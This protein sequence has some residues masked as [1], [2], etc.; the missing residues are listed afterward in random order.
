MGFFDNRG[1]LGPPPE[2]FRFGSSGKST[3]MPFRWLG[4]AALVLVGYLTISVLKTIYV[5]VL[6][7]D[8]VG[9]GGV[10]QTELTARVALFF[11]GALIA[12][13]VLG[14]NIILARRFAPVGLE[15]SFIEEVDPEAI[16]RIVAV[17]LVAG[18]LFLGVIFGSVAA[19]N[20]ETILSW[21]NSQP[22][23]REDA[24]F[25][26]DIGFYVFSL[27][28]LHLIQQWMLSLLFVSAL[29]SAGVYALSISLQRFELN[30][31]QQMRIH[32]SFLVGAIFLA[33]AASTML[34]VYDIVS[35]SGGIVY[36]AKYTDVNARLPVRYLLVALSLFAA[37]ATIANPFLSAQGFRAP[38]FAIGLWGFAGI[39]GGVLYPAIVQ[40]VTVEPNER[41]REA[42]YIERNIAA[43]RFA[44]GLDPVVETR[45]PA[46]QAVKQADLDANP[47]T[48]AN[49][50]LL[51]PIPLRDTFNQIQ[52]IRQFYTFNDVDVARY[53]INGKTQQVMAAAR[54]LDITRAQGTN[55]TR[56][57]LQLTH[58]YGAVIAPVNEVVNEGLP[59]LITSEIPPKSDVIKITEAGARIYFGEK[60]DQYVVGRSSEPE[61]DYPLGNGNAA[62]SYPED[63]GIQLNSTLRRA[64][65]AWELGDANLL[66]SGQIT[67]ES[68]LLMDR[69]I[70]QRVRKVAPFLLLDSDPYMVVIDGRIMWLQSAYTTSTRFPYAQPSGL[71][72]EVNYVRSSVQITID[73]QT[74]DMHFYL[75]DSQDPIAKTWSRI[76]P[77]LFE[78]NDAIPAAVRAHMRYPLDLF[79]LQSQLYL[80]YHITDPSVFFIGE[81]VWNIPAETKNN[82]LQAIEPYYVTMVLPDEQR[83]AGVDRAEFVL[84]M[85]F[86]PRNRQNTVA[87]LAGRSDGGNLGKLRA[88]RFPTEDLVFG[89]AQ[90]EARIDQN[91]G[92]SQQITLWNQSGSSV[93]RG[94]LL[95]IPVGTSFLFVEPIYL[96]SENSKLPELVRVV[97]ANGTQIAM[98]R[99]FPEALDVVMGKR[100]SS[101]ANGPQAAPTAPATQPGATATPARGTA[102]PTATPRPGATPTIAPATI[103]ELLR[104]AQQSSN[105]TQQELDRLRAILEAI[106]KQ[107][108]T[109]PQ[110]PAR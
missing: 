103:E 53:T 75:L 55:W 70:Q 74:G 92:I 61:F 3:P 109:Q 67:S 16:R 68:R 66:I 45:F 44:Y 23:G 17:L 108:Q 80:R 51:D 2:A 52:A 41:L 32:L 24:Q 27:P 22:F 43:T 59:K 87:W 69:Q 10:Y 79:K 46:E 102:T 95:M 72:G 77:G 25:Q 93:V 97:V 82:K 14:G 99:T 5:D 49:I 47:E 85:P 6:W 73:A 107:L 71:L 90:I 21:L 42:P 15:E 29:A 96:Q 1:D 110:T 50:R 98:E 86:T 56:E 100:P 20:W 78:P 84:I 91:P 11:A 63:R 35:S 30:L 34:N 101:L 104:Q 76:F 105:T 28:A 37:T 58:G 12:V 62:T 48:L 57:R 40:S 13:A 9:F 8:S 89:P 7:F 33:I 64:M 36:G 26:R 88:Y 106:Q 65:L 18:T 4:L 31:N 54:E 38:L 83:A 94:N 39:V 60:T 19:G 81:D